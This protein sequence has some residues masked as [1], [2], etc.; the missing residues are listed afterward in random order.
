MTTDTLWMGGSALPHHINATGREATSLLE[1]PADATHA[2]APARESSSLQD[3]N[4]CC[5]SFIN[6]IRVVMI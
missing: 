3:K 1:L 6:T 5:T 4:G 2:H